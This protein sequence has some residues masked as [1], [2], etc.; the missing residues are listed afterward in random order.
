MIIDGFFSPPRTYGGPIVKGITPHTKLVDGEY[1]WKIDK[2][3][4]YNHGIVQAL[5]DDDTGGIFLWG[6]GDPAPYIRFHHESW[7]VHIPA[8]PEVEGR[9]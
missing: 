2:R 5:K 7:F 9:S 6:C 1:Y 4:G 8:P 3:T